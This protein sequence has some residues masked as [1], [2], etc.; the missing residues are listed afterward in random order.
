M[1]TLTFCGAYSKQLIHVKNKPQI[2]SLTVYDTFVADLLF[3]NRENMQN[4]LK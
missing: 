1:R 2:V 3:S 4:Q